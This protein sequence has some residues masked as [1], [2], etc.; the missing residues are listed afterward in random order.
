MVQSP[1]I[2]PSR[3]QFSLRLWS[4]SAPK[5]VFI[6]VKS[7]CKVE[8]INYIIILSTFLFNLLQLIIRC[9]N[10]SLNCGVN[11]KEGKSFGEMRATS[12]WTVNIEHDSNLVM[13]MKFK[14][15]DQKSVHSF[16]VSVGN[17]HREKWVEA[18]LRCDLSIL[19][20]QVF[21]IAKEDKKRKFWFDDS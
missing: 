14:F 5:I 13:S 19:N 17:V 11:W 15:A 10:N 18:Y 12:F 8:T 2:L 6:Y 20:L 9:I 3:F 16:F 21:L 7:Y 1:V 4:Q